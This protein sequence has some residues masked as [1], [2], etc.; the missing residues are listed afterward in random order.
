MQFGLPIETPHEA[1]ADL[2]G[3]VLRVKHKR[4]PEEKAARYEK[5]RL[6]R[7]GSRARAA[8]LAAIAAAFC[9]SRPREFKTCGRCAQRLPVVE[10]Y[11]CMRR[12]GPR[13]HGWCKACCNKNSRE[14]YGAREDRVLPFDPVTSRILRDPKSQVRVSRERYAE[15]KAAQGGRCAICGAEKSARKGAE[16]LCVDHDHATGN[17]RALLCHQ[18]NSGIGMLAEDM[19][20]MYR[21]AE[22]VASHRRLW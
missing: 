10:F 17:I 9:L 4:T 6:Q 12:Q 8:R 13:P 20:R 19:D 11:V 14:A 21:A 3:H 1:V 15:M 5:E 22:Y 7:A 18:C 16:A 2:A